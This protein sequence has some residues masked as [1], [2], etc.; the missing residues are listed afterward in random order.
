M[1][2]VRGSDSELVGRAGLANAAN[3]VEIKLIIEND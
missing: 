2:I 3:E 1:H